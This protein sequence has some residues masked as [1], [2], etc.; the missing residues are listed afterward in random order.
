MSDAAGEN[1]WRWLNTNRANPDDGLMWL[2][3]YP[4][5]SSTGDNFDCALAVFG[6]NSSGLYF[7]NWS[8]SSPLR[9]LCEKPV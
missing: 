2:L 7:F 4:Q 9:T 1:D 6:D 8:C 3:G 5:I